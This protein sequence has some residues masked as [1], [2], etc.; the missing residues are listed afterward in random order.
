MLTHL[1]N[2]LSCIFLIITCIFSIISERK[3]NKETD[4]I[5]N[6]LIKQ[7]ME[8]KMIKTHIKLNEDEFRSLVSGG[9]LTIKS[10]DSEIMICLSDIGFHRMDAAID[11]AQ[12]GRLTHYSNLTRD[13]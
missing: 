5:I 12:S 11:D 8:N 4:F 6:R 13:L 1:L 9:I 10:K 3:R 7:N 2:V